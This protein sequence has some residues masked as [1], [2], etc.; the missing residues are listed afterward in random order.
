M[1]WMHRNKSYLTFTVL[2]YWKFGWGGIYRQ[3]VFSAA[4]ASLTLEM[5]ICRL[6]STIDATIEGKCVL[7]LVN[8]FWVVPSELS[9]CPQCWITTD[10]TA[11]MAQYVALET[12]IQSASGIKSK[13]NKKI[14]QFTITCSIEL[15]TNKKWL[16]NVHIRAILQ[17][18][19]INSRIHSGTVA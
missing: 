17:H 2:T 10:T 11:Q 14:K 4:M 16:I 19:L 15:S 12:L 1:F 7:H 18:P 6:I 5:S 8:L 3:F 9:S 13:K